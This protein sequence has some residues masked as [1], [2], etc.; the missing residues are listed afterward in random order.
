M[1]SSMILT[2]MVRGTARSAPTGPQTQAQK[3]NERITTRVD[4]PSLLPIRLG[5]MRFPNTM[6]ITP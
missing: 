3:S 2:I 6:L 5:S 4:R 1:F